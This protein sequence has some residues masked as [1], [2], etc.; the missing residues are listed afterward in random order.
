[1]TRNTG[2]SKDIPNMH[3][4]Y[5]VLGRIKMKEYDIVYYYVYHGTSAKCVPV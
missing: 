5:P 2:K 3:V 4:Q 1:M